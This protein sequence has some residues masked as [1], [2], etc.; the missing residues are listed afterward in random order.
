MEGTSREGTLAKCH[1]V[2]VTKGEAGSFIKVAGQVLRLVAP[3]T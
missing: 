1:K 3:L 2:T